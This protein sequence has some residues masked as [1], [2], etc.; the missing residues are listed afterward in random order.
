MGAVH[1]SSRFVQSASALAA[2]IDGEVVALDVDKGVC[3]GLD[4]IGSRIWAMLAQ[5]KSLAAICVAMTDAYD[6]DDAT[7]ERDVGEL[8]AD[9][10][11]EGLVR[12]VPGPPEA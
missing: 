11:A 1:A 12:L 9:L 4:P 2:E 8:L 5:P 10:A 3:Y 6:I 7:C